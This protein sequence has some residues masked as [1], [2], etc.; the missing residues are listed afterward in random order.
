MLVAINKYIQKNENTI[1]VVLTIVSLILIAI[2]GKLYFIGFFM[3]I[4][5]G[6][7]IILPIFQIL[8][9]SVINQEQ[10]KAYEEKSK[11]RSKEKDYREARVGLNI[12]KRDWNNYSTE[13]KNKLNTLYTGQ[14]RVIWYNFRNKNPHENIAYKSSKYFRVISEASKS[15]EWQNLSEEERVFLIEKYDRL[16]HKRRKVAQETEAILKEEKKREQIL[17]EQKTRLKNLESNENDFSFKF[18]KYTGLLLI[19]LI[20]FTCGSRKRVGATCNDGTP[21]Y[22]IGSGTCSHHNGV[23]HWRYEYWWD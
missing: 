7:K 9:L 4:F 12:S 8:L 16:E 15:L 13:R 14:K 22:S 2:F 11:Q 23:R 18:F 17:R 20:F 21:S 3:F 1:S 6:F 10:E 19:F 5:L